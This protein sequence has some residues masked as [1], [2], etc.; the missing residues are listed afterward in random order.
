MSSP[1]WLCTA[2]LSILLTGAHQSVCVQFTVSCTQTDWV[3]W[4]LHRTDMNSPICLCTAYLSILLIYL[5]VH[6]LPLHRA[7]QS[8]CVQLTP[9]RTDLRSPICVQLTSPSYW[10]EITH[11][12]VYSLPP[13][14]TDMRSPICLF[15]AY[16][17]IVLTWDHPSVYDLRDVLVDS[18]HVGFLPV[19]EIYDSLDRLPLRCVFLY[20]LGHSFPDSLTV[21]IESRQIHQVVSVVP[22]LEIKM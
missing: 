1:I 17:P 12:S 21:D 16:L 15:T 7:H 20:C 5:T 11:L 10:H 22:D 3:N 18:V 19:C 2:Y 14:R 4:P 9:C 6:S 8:V 13:H